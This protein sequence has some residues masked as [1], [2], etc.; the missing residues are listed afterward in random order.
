MSYYLIGMMGCGKTTLSK[1]LSEILDKPN[2][3]IDEQIQYNENKSISN[4]FKCKGEEYFRE[5]ESNILFKTSNLDGFVSCGGG[6]ILRKKNRSFL[7]KKNTIFLF[8]DP[9]LLIERIDVTKRPILKGQKDNL[10]NIWEQR[11]NYYDYCG[12]KIDLTNLTINESVASILYY[13]QKKLKLYSNDLFQKYHLYSNIFPISKK[14]KLSIISENVNKIYGEK[15]TNKKIILPNGEKAK[16]IKSLEKIYSYFIKEKINKNDIICGIGGG[17]I[18]DITSFAASTFKRGICFD[19]FPTTLIGQI[20]ASLGGKT[21][22]N[23]ESIKNAIGNFSLPNNVY[24]DVMSLFSLEDKNYYDGIFEALKMY[25]IDGKEFDNF[26]N[27]S[28]K[29][30]LK[31]YSFLIS[32]LKEC[33]LYKLKIVNED[34]YDKGIRNILNFGH[35]FGHALESS[36]NYSH[37]EAVAWGMLAE[38]NFLIYCINNN[39]LSN[40]HSFL[41]LNKKNIISTYEKIKYFISLFL[42]K[43]LLNKKI[44]KK[45]F[46]SALI[47][48]KKIIN[49]NII[50]MPIIYKPGKYYFIEMEFSIIK[51][52]LREGIIL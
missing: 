3:D 7:K 27:N 26:I 19:L 22:I 51:N 12:T 14:Y 40:V 44:N 6:I 8:V 15:I 11:K 2:I 29:I 20:D 24:I 25:L 33:T 50:R 39:Y 34:Y 23:Y 46:Y 4:I 38:M 42:D 13:I 5:L 52:W 47:N 35:S 28:N 49:K 17:T 43:N 16:S 31:N 10:L 1:K 36:Y 30:Y 9:K 48:D 45:N 37:G 18:T 41:Y 32:V 21:G